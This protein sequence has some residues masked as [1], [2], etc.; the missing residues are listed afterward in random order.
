M[1]SL[2]APLLYLYRAATHATV[3]AEPVPG[4]LDAQ[5][6]FDNNPSSKSTARATL[7]PQISDTLSPHPS[8]KLLA[9]DTK[10]AK[11]PYVC[12]DNGANDFLKYNEYAAYQEYAVHIDIDTSLCEFT[13]MPQYFVSLVDKS[14]K[15]PWIGKIA[16]ESS[17]VRAAPTRFRIIIWDPV[18]SSAELLEIATKHKWAVTWLG[19]T[20]STSGRTAAY[21][22]GW[23]HGDTTNLIYTDVNTASAGFAA[24]SKPPRYFASLYGM[25]SF[26]GIDHWRT[27]G[28]NVVYTPTATGFR[29]YVLLLERKNK[30][31][32]F[33]VK[34]VVK[35]AE[36]LGWTVGW[37]GSADDSISGVS[38][39]GNWKKVPHTGGA[40]SALVQPPTHMVKPIFIASVTVDKGDPKDWHCSGTPTVG[41]VTRGSFK[42]YLGNVVRPVMLEKQHV[43]MLAPPYADQH[44]RVNYLAYDVPRNSQLVIVHLRLENM[45]LESF[46]PDRKRQMID[47]LAGVLRVA[48]SD[49]AIFN[50]HREPGSPNNIMCR[51]QVKSINTKMAAKI[52]QTMK[53]QKF[54]SHLSQV[55]QENG[56]DS[57]VVASKDMDFTNE[58]ET[59]IPIYGQGSS[60]SMLLYTLGMCL[61][62]VLGF[63]IHYKISGRGNQVTVHGGSESTGFGFGRSVNLSPAGLMKKAGMRYFNQGVG[64]NGT[65]SD[66]VTA[67][68]VGGGWFWE[69][70]SEVRQETEM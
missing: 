69:E 56:R 11:K 30:E 14:G 47:D 25:P 39:T 26:Q 6:F 4:A 68:V 16:G 37:T 67:R 59:D 33:V 52:I 53:T 3:D 63:L 32:G 42:L 50:L 40:I 54:T 41:H 7:A 35:K 43:P 46:T 65:R 34:D 5:I 24:G 60:N 12:G 29:V 20:G 49:V 70:N 15:R 64:S 57:F 55:M 66:K 58:I 51:V 44:W 27:S 10:S 17:I 1:L 45:A 31:D 23:Q 36:S 61:A 19:V 2:M 22:T 18:M 9:S 38:S 8:R 21:K 48:V 13:E 62:A 28:C